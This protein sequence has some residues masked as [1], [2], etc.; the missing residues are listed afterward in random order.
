MDVVNYVGC[1]ILEAREQDLHPFVILIGSS[2]YYRN[3][4]ARELKFG[5]LACGS[6]MYHLAAPVRVR[7]NSLTLIESSTMLFDENHR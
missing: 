4:K 7:W 5:Y 6:S 3:M 1:S 2:K